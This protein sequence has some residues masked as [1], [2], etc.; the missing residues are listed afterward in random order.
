MK[1]SINEFGDD[2]KIINSKGMKKRRPRKNP[3]PER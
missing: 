2:P 1:D 3:G